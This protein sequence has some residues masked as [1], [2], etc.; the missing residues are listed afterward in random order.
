PQ[1]YYY[2]GLVLR[3]QSRYK[4]A[5]TAFRQS[6]RLEPDLVE[7]HASLGLVLR[8]QGRLSE[9]L[10]SLRRAQ[11]LAS[12]RLGRPAPSTASIRQCER[13]VLLAPHLPAV[14][15]GDTEPATPAERIE[16]AQL[17]RYK[18]L[19]RSAARLFA[20]AVAAEPTLGE[21]PA[22]GFRYGAV[23]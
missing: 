16:Y 20:D 14:L 1:T 21:N 5:E 19:F 8:N 23:C 6:L 15:A 3:A 2:L 18:R 13:L 11:A 22:S 4:D 12:T 17:C 9:A 10:Q 7:A